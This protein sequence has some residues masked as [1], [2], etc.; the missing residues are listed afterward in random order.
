M[1]HSGFSQDCSDEVLHP[2]PHATLAFAAHRSHGAPSS[3]TGSLVLQ[4]C[5]AV[6]LVS[7]VFVLESLRPPVLLTVEYGS[8]E[9]VFEGKATGATVLEAFNA[10][11]TAG[12][13]PFTLS[14]NDGRVEIIALN[15][16]YGAPF[17]NLS[18][19]VR[20]GHPLDPAHLDTVRVKPG[21]RVFIRFQ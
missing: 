13:I 4:V 12:N 1:L 3:G 17:G 8:T 21:D 18:S 7:V 2:T 15:G 6:M 5:A 14:V 16:H 20:N 19:V 10:S 9:R 11:A